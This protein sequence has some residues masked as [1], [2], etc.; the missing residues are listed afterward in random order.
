[1][2][3][4]ETLLEWVS[5]LGHPVLRFYAW[6]EPAATFGY[7]QRVSDVATWTTLRPLIRRPTGGGL[8]PHDADWTYSLVVPPGHEW[9]RLKAIASYQRIHEWLHRAFAAL[10]MRTEL[11]AVE[12]SKTPGKCFI[13]AE[14][15]DLLWNGAK[16]AG[17]AQRR[18]KGGLL[19]QG[20][21][22]PPRDCVIERSEWQ[23]AMFKAGAAVGVLSWELFQP[24]TDLL[25]RA[26]ELARSK[27]SQR[28]H[29]E[30]R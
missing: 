3:L 14:K 7:A 11:A 23:R 26:D 29:N 18:N 27:Y 22:Q 16:L 6:S 2:A 8:V 19:I 25:Q 1:M 24:D 12:Q 17:A 5:T 9:Y 20:S 15:F 28:Q 21:I 30:R 13:G 4:D 10:R